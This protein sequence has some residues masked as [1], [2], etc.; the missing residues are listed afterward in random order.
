MTDNATGTWALRRAKDA[1]MQWLDARQRMD[2][3]AVTLT[4]KR[5]VSRKMIF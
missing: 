1:V 3:M 4:P 5:M 2:R